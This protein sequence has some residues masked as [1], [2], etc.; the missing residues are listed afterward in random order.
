MDNDQLLIAG[1]VAIPVIGLV[2][3]SRRSGPA[4]A[5]VVTPPSEAYVEAYRLEQMRVTAL[6]EMIRQ[7][8]ADRSAYQITATKAKADRD[9][10][11]AKLATEYELR[12][13]ELPIELEIARAEARARTDIAS[14]MAK[15]QAAM[16][17]EQRK[18]G[19]K[20]WMDLA[21]ASLPF[22]F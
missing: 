5:T 13:L 14:E 16:A 1:A 10:G 20:T 3:L 15:A 12:K 9:L 11:L 22:L 18:A 6:S 17:K 21:I 8:S 7:L 4:G 19:Q 2:L